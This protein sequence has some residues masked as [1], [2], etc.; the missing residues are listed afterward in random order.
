MT[1]FWDKIIEQYLNINKANIKTNTIQQNSNNFKRLYIQ[2]EFNSLI[3]NHKEKQHFPV[4]YFPIT[5]SNSI[6]KEYE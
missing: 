6:K 3:I 2:K 1:I 5:L 4:L